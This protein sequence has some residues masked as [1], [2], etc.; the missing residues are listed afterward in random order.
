[1]RSSS[2]RALTFGEIL[3]CVNVRFRSHEVA[4]RPRAGS[5]HGQLNAAKLWNHESAY[6]GAPVPSLLVAATITIQRIGWEGS[7][8]KDYWT[9][10]ASQSQSSPIDEF[11]QILTL[12]FD[13]ESEREAT[14]IQNAVYALVEQARA[15]SSLVESN[16]LETIA[17]MIAHLDKRLSA[18]MNEIMHAPEFQQI[19]STWARA[20]ISAVSVRDRRDA[21][22]SRHERLQGRTPTESVA[23]P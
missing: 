12:G 7:H 11:V 22:D 14:E 16:V 15:N 23:I 8:G 5:D 21:K 2:L 1:V 3:I 19:E 20:Q 18:Q 17:A 6:R 9:G 4:S 10:D 13:P